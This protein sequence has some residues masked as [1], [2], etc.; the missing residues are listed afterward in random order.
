MKATTLTD[1]EIYDS[2]DPLAAL[3]AFTADDIDETVAH[4]E[5]DLSDLITEI[6]PEKPVMKSIRSRNA[7]GE[8]EGKYI[9]FTKFGKWLFKLEW[10]EDDDQTWDVFR[11]LSNRGLADHLAAREFDQLLE[12]EDWKHI[13]N[14]PIMRDG[15][16]TIIDAA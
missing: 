5:T 13:D 2:P 10:R 1:N 11:R 8:M 3:H 14:V 7:D 15:V 9:S 12:L 4:E 16:A 6:Q